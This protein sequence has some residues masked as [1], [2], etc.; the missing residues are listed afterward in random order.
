MAAFDSESGRQEPRD[1][2]R[3]E[4]RGLSQKWEPSRVGIDFRLGAGDSN[5]F[6]FFVS[7][8]LKRAYLD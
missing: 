1:W 6:T 7:S 2:Y 8:T 3:V 4:I 5:W